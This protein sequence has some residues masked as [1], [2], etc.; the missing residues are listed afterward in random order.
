MRIWAILALGLLIGCGGTATDELA[1][2]VDVDGQLWSGRLIYSSD[3]TDKL[4]TVV[5]QQSGAQI[6]GALYYARPDV[7]IDLNAPPTCLTR[8]LVVNDRLYMNCFVPN[9]ASTI[10]VVGGFSGATF[11][12][13]YIRT[14]ASGRS[15]PFVAL[16]YVRDVDTDDFFSNYQRSVQRHH[17]P[18]GELTVMTAE[19]Q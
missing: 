8:G 18:S 3:Q 16:E 7:G 5:F 6:A 1:G 12:G 9:E 14:F 19:G 15:T 11:R 2:A 13:S 17:D 10:E 4:M